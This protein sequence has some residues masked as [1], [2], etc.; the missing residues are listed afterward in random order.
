MNPA[1]HIGEEIKNHLNAR[2]LPV[3]WLATKL[4]CDASALRKALKKSW[5]T[6]DLLFRISLLLQK[7]FFACYSQILSEEINQ[8]KIAR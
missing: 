2:K 5:L 8:A 3:A 7:D 4:G 6:T 1:I